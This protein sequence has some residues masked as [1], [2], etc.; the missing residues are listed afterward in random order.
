MGEATL[1]TWKRFAISMVIAFVAPAVVM[2]GGLIV[3]TQSQWLTDKFTDDMWRGLIKEDQRRLAERRA[4][5][6]TQSRPM[7]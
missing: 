2:Y 1:M 3:I 6:T 7:R 4:T 5:W